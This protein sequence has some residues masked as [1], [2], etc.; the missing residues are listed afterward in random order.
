MG[1]FIDP[2]INVP[3]RESKAE[4]WILW[5]NSIK[6]KVGK[7]DAINLFIDA[8]KQRGTDE[9]NTTE[10][11][12]HVAKDGIIIGADWK[13]IIIDTITA[14]FDLW[15]TI[16]SITQKVGIGVSIV[17]AIFILAI[18]GAIIMFIY[19]SAKNPEMVIKSVSAGATGGLGLK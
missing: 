19:K 7:D 9:A 12:E 15:S 17:V 4:Q 11:R 3:S 1:K 2:V 5:Y 14:P 16:S 10:L 6:N 8:W 13:D 18:L